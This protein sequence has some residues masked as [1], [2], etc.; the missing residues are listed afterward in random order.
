MSTY[1]AFAVRTESIEVCILPRST[2][3]DTTA[4]RACACPLHACAAC[5][6]NHIEH[7]GRMSLELFTVCVMRST[8]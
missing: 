2:W 1:R 3:T 4:I 6:S 5:Y 8:L 7:L